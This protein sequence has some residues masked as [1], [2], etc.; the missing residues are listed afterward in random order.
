MTSIY[1]H[2]YNNT[3]DLCFTY[4]VHTPETVNF[5]LIAICINSHNVVHMAIYY[6]VIQYLDFEHW[7]I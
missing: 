5:S 2:V 6:A 7:I 3:V 4:D 1:V